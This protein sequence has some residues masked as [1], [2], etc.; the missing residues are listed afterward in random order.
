MIRII[1][2]EARGRMLATPEGQQTTRPSSERVREA[3]FGSIQFDLLDCRVLDLFAGS[4]AL[5]FEAVS[6]G[7]AFALCND[8]DRRSVACLTENRCALGFVE[9]VQIKSL[10]Y[11]ECLRQ[12]ADQQQRFDFIFVDPPYDLGAYDDVIERI[13]AAKLLSETGSLFIEHSGNWRCDPEN[14]QRQGMQVRRS[15]KYGK[16]ILE[17]LVWV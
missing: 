16:A 10:E 8:H 12:L 17:R 6:R 15:K 1:A 13:S 5:A 3:L 2:G 9:R 14:I 4:G 11:G 7:A